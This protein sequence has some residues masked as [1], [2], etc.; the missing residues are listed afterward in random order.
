MTKVI[1]Y[2]NDEG[3]FTT[4]NSPIGSDESFLLNE[5]KNCPSGAEIV[6]TEQFLQ[7]IASN[8]FQAWEIE[9]N[10][11]TLN[12]DKA[13]IIQ[14]KRLDD[15][16]AQYIKLKPE[17]YLNLNYQNDLIVMQNKIKNSNTLEDIFSSL[18]LFLNY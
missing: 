2:I 16:N 3:F 12:I 4:H 1:V 5:L 15:F 18:I 11:I 14:L 9:N 13:K 6:D 10:I 17:L 7:G 8:F